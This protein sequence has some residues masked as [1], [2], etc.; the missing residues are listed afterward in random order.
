VKI[1]ELLESHSVGVAEEDPAPLTI[2]F[3]V[4]ENSPLK[5]NPI[6]SLD[7]DEPVERW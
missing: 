3:W 2:N 6:A 1:E 4:L 5:N 7:F